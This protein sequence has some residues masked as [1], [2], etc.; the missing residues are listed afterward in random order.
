MSQPKIPKIVVCKKWER[1][2]VSQRLVKH[3]GLASFTDS[4][5]TKIDLHDNDDIR[6][7]ARRIV[8]SAN[9]RDINYNRRGMFM[10]P[11]TISSHPV[12]RRETL[13]ASAITVEGLKLLEAVNGALAS[14]FN[15]FLVLENRIPSPPAKLTQKGLS[16]GSDQLWLCM[17]YHRLRFKID[18]IFHEFSVKPYQALMCRGPAFGTRMYH[19]A[20]P[21]ERGL[22]ICFFKH[23]LYQDHSE[24]KQR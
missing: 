13:R 17:S 19:Y 6:R 20:L 16:H 21:P 22:L 11:T 5:A 3:E 4:S 18:C 10:A 23:D 12:S 9:L 8:Q 7:L 24:L 14:N 15:S 2:P 1:I